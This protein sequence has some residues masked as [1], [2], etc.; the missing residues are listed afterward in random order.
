MC[1]LDRPGDVRFDRARC[2]GRSSMYTWCKSYRMHA[3]AHTHTHTHTHTHCKQSKQGNYTTPH[4]RRQDNYTTPHAAPL[5][6]RG[7][8]L[9]GHGVTMKRRCTYRPWALQPDSESC[10]D[11]IVKTKLFRV[12]VSLSLS[13]PLRLSGSL[14]LSDDKWILLVYVRWPNPRCSSR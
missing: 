13:L 4:A 14:S 3:T 12:R 11:L 2:G 6:S 7:S 9:Q 5:S 8:S 1:D 10:I